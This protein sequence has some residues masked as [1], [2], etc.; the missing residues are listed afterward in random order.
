MRRL[1]L[2]RLGY[3]CNSNNIFCILIIDKP[4]AND[5]HTHLSDCLVA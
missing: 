5:N 3:K 4:Q 1:L 2:T